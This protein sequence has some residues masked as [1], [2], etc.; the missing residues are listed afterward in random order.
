MQTATADLNINP[1]TFSSALGLKSVY[2]TD[3]FQKEFPVIHHTFHQ[4][5]LDDHLPPVAEHEDITAEVRME[6]TG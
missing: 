1:D 5:V 6:F 4:L 3:L 2:T